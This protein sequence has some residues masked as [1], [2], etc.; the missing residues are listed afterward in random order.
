MRGAC[1]G[2]GRC[3]ACGARG[4]V[5]QGPGQH[6]RLANLPIIDHASHIV[7][8]HVGNPVHCKML[9][10]TLLEDYGIYVQ[11][12]NY[13]TVARGTERLRITP[14]PQHT[15]AQMDHLVNALSELWA[16]CPVSQIASD[17]GKRAAE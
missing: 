3:G 11:P 8:V 7:P 15:D 10:D 9:S 2:R 16:Q 13:P 5:P 4:Q 12:I 6:P 14:Q 17:E 1:W